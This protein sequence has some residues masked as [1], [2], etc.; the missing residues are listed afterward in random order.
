R[1]LAQVVA[2]LDEKDPRWRLEE[3][4]EDR[5]EVPEAENGARCVVV[6]GK[7]LPPGWPKR[8]W[9][10]KFEDLEPNEQLD[11]ERFA[12]LRKELGEVKGALAEARKLADRPR[13]RHAIEYKR[14]VL[15]TLLKD[16]DQVRR[17]S[18]LLVLDALGRGQEGDPRAAL[19]SCRAALNA[20]RS[21]GD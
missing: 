15:H 13:G 6:A 9:D 12:L 1:K 4:E 18:R 14:A 5:A 10:E 17:V 16:Q 11:G 19:R 3:I 2:E 20:G 8:E 7:L 21:L